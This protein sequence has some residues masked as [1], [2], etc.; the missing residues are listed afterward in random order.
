ME[1]MMSIDISAQPQQW[2]GWLLS[3]SQTWTE[4]GLQGPH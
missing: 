2:E 4:P 3:V 1:G